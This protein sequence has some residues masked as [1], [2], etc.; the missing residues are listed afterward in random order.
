L[1]YGIC[2]STTKKQRKDYV[3]IKSKLSNHNAKGVVPTK[4]PTEKNFY[5]PKGRNKAPLL[6][7][8]LWEDW[9]NA[10][11]PSPPT[12]LRSIEVQTKSI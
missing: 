6:N 11:L 10:M 3:G 1:K 4:P 2:A 9:E 8:K 7:A 12:P 5:I